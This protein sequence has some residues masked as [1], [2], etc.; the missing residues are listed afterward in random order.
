MENDDK[1][2]EITRAMTPEQEL[3]APVLVRAE[4]KA[5]GLRSLYPDWS[6]EKIQKEVRHAFLIARG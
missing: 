3:N 6:E 4:L 5:A 2:R 1:A